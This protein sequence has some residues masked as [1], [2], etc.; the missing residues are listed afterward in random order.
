MTSKDKV[1]FLEE[2]RLIQEELE[3]I[4]SSV[5]ARLKRNPRVWTNHYSVLAELLPSNGKFQTESVSNK[6]YKIVKPERSRKQVVSQQHEIKLFLQKRVELLHNLKKLDKSNSKIDITSIDQLKESVNELNQENCDKILTLNDRIGEYSMF[7]L[8]NDRAK[9]NTVLSKM[10]A[11]LKIDELFNRQELYGEYMDLEPIF[12]RWLSVVRDSSV[13]I[14]KF[15]TQF[16]ECFILKDDRENLD[17]HIL[18]PPMDRK[19]ERYVTF[20]QYYHD[21]VEKFFYT[22]YCLLNR[23][24]MDK[25]LL[26]EFQNDY[27]SNPITHGGGKLFCLVCNRNFSNVNVFGNHLSGKQHNKLLQNREQFYLHEFK[28]HKYLNTLKGTY[29]DTLQFIERK[30]AFTAKERLEEIERIDQILNSP[31]YDYVNE[32]EQV[33]NQ[34]KPETDSKSLDNNLNTLLEN[35]PHTIV[36]PDGVPIPHW[37]YKLQG[38]DVTFTCEIC[39]NQVFKGRRSFERHF[40][41]ARHQYNL[42]CLGIT[43]SSAFK[44]ISSI[45]QAQ[46]L[47]SKMKKHTAKTEAAKLEVEV[48]DDEGN[49]YTEQVA[50]DL[51]KQGLW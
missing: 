31:D 20:I 7:S 26:K 28:L 33:N 6:V 17:Y 30:I 41:E 51:Q 18:R 37:L 8:A 40:R 14:I 15:L 50:H 47:W 1:L 46:Q 2:K 5:T 3:I 42:Q 38:L 24:V 13:T 25:Q 12:N 32:I 35:I 22:K 45:D 48:E 23:L 21:Y 36:G 49:V 43:P 16:Q 11:N 4:E 39:S 34:H 29:Q 19:N 27:I 9:P 44:G 10:A